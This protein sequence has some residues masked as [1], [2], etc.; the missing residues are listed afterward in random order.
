LRV[1]KPLGDSL[2]LAD[3]Y[4]SRGEAVAASDSEMLAACLDMASLEAIFAAP[5]GGAGLVAVQKLAG[6]K[7]IDRKETVVLF[8][9]GSGYKYIEAWRAALGI[10]RG[11]I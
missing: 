5:E 6:Q 10:A 11:V 8:N 3:L 2:I 7:K 9:T 1:P 4:A